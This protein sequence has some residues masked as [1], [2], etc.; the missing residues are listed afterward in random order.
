M[1]TSQYDGRR[2]TPGSVRRDQRFLKQNPWAR[3]DGGFIVNAGIAREA[4]FASLAPNQLRNLI[5]TDVIG[6]AP[7]EQSST[8]KLWNKNLI[9]K[10]MFVTSEINSPVYTDPRGSAYRPNFYQRYGFQFHYNPTTIQMSY[11]GNPDFDVTMFTSGREAF[12]L[13]GAASTQSTISFNIVLNRIHDMKYFGGTGRFKTGIQTSDWSGK[14]P[15]VKEQQQ[16]YN[17]GTMYDIEYFLRT[18]MQVKI[19]AA[20]KQRNSFDGQTADMGFL[21]GIP[22]DLHLGNGLRYWVRI[23]AFNLNHVIFNERM[24]PLF[25]E[26]AITC[27]RIPDYAADANKGG[28]TTAGPAASSPLTEFEMYPEN[29]TGVRVSGIPTDYPENET[30]SEEYDRLWADYGG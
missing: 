11:A 6:N 29:F 24:V 30:L 5:R 15:T 13:L 7:T 2:V 19:P 4:Y 28:S 27:S 22:V 9:T 8:T 1:P 23:D 18:V 17:K 25:T 21:T 14:F 26:V 12:N 3:K 20:L 16:I 10:G